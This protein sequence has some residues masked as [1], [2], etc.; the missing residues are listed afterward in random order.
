MYT[1][2]VVDDAVIDDVLP[3]AAE[4]QVDLEMKQ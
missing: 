3:G 2:S 4:I 1:S